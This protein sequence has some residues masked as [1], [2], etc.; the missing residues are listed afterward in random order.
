[1]RQAS[2]GDLACNLAMQLARPLKAAPRQIAEQLVER[3]RALDGATGSSS[4]EALEIAGPGFINIRLRD[5]AKRAAVA[6]VL[7]DGPAFGR[8]T[9]GGGR[10]VV[11]EFVSANPTGPLHVGH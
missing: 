11:V 10:K 2:L 7:A 3:V 4:I 8:D 1:P 6:R 9:R 5:E